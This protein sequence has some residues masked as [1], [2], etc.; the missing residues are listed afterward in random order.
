MRKVTFEGGRSEGG[1]ELAMYTSEETA[2]WQEEIASPNAHGVEI[3]LAW[4][5][6]AKRP[7]GSGGE[8]WNAV[9]G[10]KVRD[11][12]D[13]TMEGFECF[14]MLNTWHVFS[15]RL[16]KLSPVRLVACFRRRGQT[17]WM[18]AKIEFPQKDLGKM[19]E[20]D[21]ESVVQLA[22][23]RIRNSLG[24]KQNLEEV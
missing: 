22:G 2:F 13:Q 8:K 10:D 5:E 6:L 17:C 9:G 1:E 15:I 16:E 12:I 7:G 23:N 11:P 20:G 19:I 24:R 3:N 18:D 14:L 4:K 21:I